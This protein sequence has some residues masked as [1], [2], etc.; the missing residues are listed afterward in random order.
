MTKTIALIAATAASLIATAVPAAARHAGS[1]D[2]M[3]LTYRQASNDFCIRTGWGIATTA[4]NRLVRKG[5]CHAQRAWLARGVAIEMPQVP[6]AAM[7]VPA[8]V[9]AR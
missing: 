9:V 8:T 4:S 3:T 6:V 1:F 2:P 5:D 7:V